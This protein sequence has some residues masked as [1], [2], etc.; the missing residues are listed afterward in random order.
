MK[1][2]AELFEGTI[3]RLR[4]PAELAKAVAGLER[5]GSLRRR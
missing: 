1:S 5:R 4:E 2:Q 3:A